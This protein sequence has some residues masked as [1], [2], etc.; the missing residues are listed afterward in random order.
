MLKK[1]GIGIVITLVIIVMAFLMYVSDY[2]KADEVAM[3]IYSQNGSLEF[4]GVSEEYGFIIYPGGKV[5]EKAYVGIA[6][7]LSEKGYT[8][9][10]VDFPFNIGFLGIEKADKVISDYPNIKKWV[11][12]GHSLGGVSGAVYA[13]ENSDKIDGLVFLASYSTKDLKDD[14]IRVMSLVGGNDTVL[15]KEGALAALTNYNDLNEFVIEGGNH[16]GFGN[17]GLQD[18]DGENTIGNEEQQRITVEKIVEFIQ[19]TEKK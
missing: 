8:T 18:G 13:D 1:F 2:S 11:I 16:A 14:D 6:K 9:V 12:I 10:I 17:Y 4:L 15:N 5:D 19:G 7:S 3:D